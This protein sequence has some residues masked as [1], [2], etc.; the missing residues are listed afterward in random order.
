MSR[1][2]R[3]STEVDRLRGCWKCLSWEHLIHS[4]A[5][6]VTAEVER[7]QRWDRVSRPAWSGL[8]GREGVSALV[9]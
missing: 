7:G 8:L 4:A 9:A 6:T 1:G 2:G 3:G 5:V